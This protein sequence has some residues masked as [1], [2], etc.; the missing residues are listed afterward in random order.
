MIRALLSRA[1]SFA[2]VQLD[3]AR[4]WAHLIGEVARAGGPTKWA[5]DADDHLS[6]LEDDNRRMRQALGVQAAEVGDALAPLADACGMPPNLHVGGTAFG[7][8]VGVADV[9]KVATEMLRKASAAI[10][11]KTTE[12]EALRA[13]VA[14][15]KELTT[16]AAQAR[17]E[18]KERDQARIAAALKHVCPKCSAEEK[19]PCFVNV[20]D[21]SGASHKTTRAPH[22]E[23]FRA[24]FPP[25]A[26]PDPI[27]TQDPS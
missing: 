1:R 24:A 15:L 13:E 5:A 26:R 9:A 17:K 12:I 16:Q 7:T 4:D 20:V 6:N 14:A 18:R 22:E 27:D 19:E 25:A 10:Y 8:G 21:A 2:L 3:D 11:E 23:R